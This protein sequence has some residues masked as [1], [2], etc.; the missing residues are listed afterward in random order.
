[1][2]IRLDVLNA[3]AVLVYQDNLIDNQLFIEIRHMATSRNILLVAQGT[4]R[5][6]MSLG[7]T[8]T[9]FCPQAVDHETLSWLIFGESGTRI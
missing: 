4:K 5:L 9:A 1:M 7:T 2:Y 3:S 8:C 6:N